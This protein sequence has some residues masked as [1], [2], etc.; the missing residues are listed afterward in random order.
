MIVTLGC[1]VHPAFRGICP[2]P[3]PRRRISDDWAAIWGA[4][5]LWSLLLLSLMLSACSPDLNWREWRTPEAGL[6]Q[7]FPCKPVRQQRRVDLG[8]SAVQMV[9]QVCDGAGAT[10]AVAHADVVDPAAVGPAL[11][12]L[13]K[14][15][16]ANLGASVGAAQTALVPGSTPQAHAGRYR[17]QGKGSDGRDLDEAMLVFARGTVVFQVTAL[18]PRLVNDDVEAFLASVRVGP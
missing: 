5:A 13:T 7:L 10:W 8:G 3:G 18:A 1:I 11:Q 6:T 4:H 15:A 14:S 2:S 17:F 12:V 16:H 9:L